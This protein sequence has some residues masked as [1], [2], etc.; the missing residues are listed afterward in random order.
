MTKEIRQLQ[1]ESRK[2][3]N[4]IRSLESDAKRREMVLKRRQDEVHIIIL[5]EVKE[6]GCIFWFSCQLC[7]ER[8]GT[9]AVVSQQQLLTT[10]P[11]TFLQTPVVLVASRWLL[12]R[13]P[14]VPQG[15]VPLL[16]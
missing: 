12:P 6:H 9:L 13:S 7:D 11:H 10:Q 15:I 14:K 5:V 4:K 2:R 3:D 8:G 1:K 16:H